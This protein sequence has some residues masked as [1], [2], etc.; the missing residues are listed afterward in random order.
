MML[1]NPC[2]N[3]KT[4]EDCPDR[5]VGCHSNCEKWKEYEVLR[6]AEY[7][8]RKEYMDTIYLYKNKSR[9]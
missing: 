2:R 3:R 8:R 7:K 9:R 4:N 5:H 1:K 6:N